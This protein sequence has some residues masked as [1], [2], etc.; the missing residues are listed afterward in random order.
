MTSEDD[1][2]VLPDENDVSL[3]SA[4]ATDFFEHV[5]E[6]L[7]HCKGSDGR[8]PLLPSFLPPAGYWTSEE[9]DIFFHGL[10]IHSRLR[11]DL[12]AAEIK[13]KTVVDVCV[14]LDMLEEATS[15]LMTDIGD[16][17]NARTQ[18]STVILRRELPAASEVSDEWI[19]VE[20][21]KALAIIRA[22]PEMFERELQE[23]RDEEIRLHRIR[24]RARKGEARTASNERDR[25][26]EKRRRK[27]FEQWLK[28]RT[29]EWE[30]EDVLRTLDAAA[31]QALDRVLRDGEKSRG[32]ETPSDSQQNAT[33]GSQVQF[34][35][36]GS[37]ISQEKGDSI[38]QLTSHVTPV[39]AGTSVI[40]PVLL[41][42]SGFSQIQPPPPTPVAPSVPPLITSTQFQPKTPPFLTKSLPDE[43]HH[44]ASTD[45]I[46]HLHARIPSNDGEAK[47]STEADELASLSPA[48]RRRHQKKL[49]MRR[50]R[51]QTTGAAIDET[52]QRLKPGRKGKSKPSGMNTPTETEGYSSQITGTTPSSRIQDL[53]P[54]SAI[55]ERSSQANSLDDPNHNQE[56]GPADP[57]G[58]SRNSR[59]SG[60]TRT[61]K[62]GAQ[63]TDVGIDAD[64]LY[65]EGLA[66]FHMNRLAKLMRCV[67]PADCPPGFESY[68]SFTG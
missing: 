65:D 62:I 34:A 7:G 6:F 23:E 47:T 24:T 42:M 55:N 40:D 1:S 37:S 9:K 30:V 58:Q 43:G 57:S 50:K 11:P 8:A 41:A 66:L 56:P 25:E 44:S 45:N 3:D 5:R 32:S 46:L 38:E 16:H 18:R 20:E 17:V 19:A 28:D 4:Y 22:K 21:Q 60:A 64:W 39:E 54:T 14:Y 13:T 15:K 49:Y 12:I 51:A 10:T 27:E 2:E 48:S 26:G 29:E 33:H 68:Q 53:L 31:L 36:G 52:I 63:M 67:L 59:S 35:D 61:Y